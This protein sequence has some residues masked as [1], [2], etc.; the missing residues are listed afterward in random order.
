MAGLCLV[1]VLLKVIIK[2]CSRLFSQKKTLAVCKIYSFVLVLCVLFAC[3]QSVIL[4]SDCG[5]AGE[6]HPWC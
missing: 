6:I 2:D 1:N 3:N 4:T 5:G